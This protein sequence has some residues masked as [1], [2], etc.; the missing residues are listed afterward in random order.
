MTADSMSTPVYEI[1][2]D[3]MRRPWVSHSFLRYIHAQRL[4]PRRRVLPILGGGLLA[5]L[6]HAM[7][8]AT[9][10]IY[11]PSS[12]LAHSPGP[13]GPGSID[14]VSDQEPVMTLILIDEPQPIQKAEEPTTAEPLASRGFTSADLLIK[15]L[16]PDVNPAVDLDASKPGRSIVPSSLS[17]TARALLFT[18]Y[19]GQ[20]DARIERAWVRPRTPIST[21]I[22]HCRVSVT[23]DHQGNVLQTEL[24]SC[25]GD[26][27]WRLSLVD[28]I[29]SA[30][31]LPAPPD[32][33]VFADAL[34]MEFESTPFLAG[35]DDQ[36]FEPASPKTIAA[37]S[38]KP[39]ETPQQR[40]E[41]QL[42]S[43]NGHRIIHL[44]IVGTSVTGGAANA[45]DAYS[46]PPPL[47]DEAPTSPAERPDNGDP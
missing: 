35:Q 11:D 16:S 45:N 1:T 23:Q 34:T 3:S 36:G 24:Q 42:S 21:T 14:M 43:P 17:A 10:L 13:S 30:S 38:T 6:A 33:R 47:L 37:L 39:S 19:V 8:I 28:A 46:P 18:R 4:I 15:L 20:V 32:P 40:L 31:P 25:N 5:L 27:R 44:Q 7:L 29:Q 26:T 22:F 2:A 12:S 9:A 41:E